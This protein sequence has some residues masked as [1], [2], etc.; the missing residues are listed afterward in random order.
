GPPLSPRSTAP[1]CGC[2]GPD[3]FS[4]LKSAV[5]AWTRVLCHLQFLGS[6][7]G[8]GGFIRQRRWLG[9]LVPV[10]EHLQDQQVFLR[11]EQDQLFSSVQDDL[12]DPIAV[13]GYHGLAEE[14]IG[15]LPG[16]S[17]RSQVILLADGIER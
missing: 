17:V 12:G 13:L 3:I 8:L 5:E 4:R 6:H 9:Y 16:G 1:S 11:P 2:R 15:L 7:L 10:M 14:R